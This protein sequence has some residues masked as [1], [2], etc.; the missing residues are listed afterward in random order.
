MLYASSLKIALIFMYF[1]VCF[2]I[3]NIPAS[4]AVTGIPLIRVI[5]VV[6]MPVHV[7]KKHP[8]EISDPKTA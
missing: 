8:A 1:Y 2:Y 3:A 6:K 5:T 7:P 4:A